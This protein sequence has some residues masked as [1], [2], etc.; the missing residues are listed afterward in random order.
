MKIMGNPLFSIQKKSKR[1]KILMPKTRFQAL[2]CCLWDY[3]SRP[4]GGY[5]TV[6]LLF[7]GLVQIRFSGVMLNIRPAKKR[8]RLPV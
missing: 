1:L 7:L 4:K 2:I 3:F 8:N 6:F 5:R